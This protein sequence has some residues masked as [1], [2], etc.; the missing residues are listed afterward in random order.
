MGHFFQ[1][2]TYVCVCLNQETEEDELIN[3]NNLEKCWVLC[4]D[5]DESCETQRCCKPKAKLSAKL[6]TQSL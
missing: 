5:D 6:S 1:T 2:S 3:N 4:K